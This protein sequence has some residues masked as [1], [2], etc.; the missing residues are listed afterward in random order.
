MTRGAAYDIADH[1]TYWVA[2]ISGLTHSGI[3]IVMSRPDRAPGL[4]L[5]RFLGQLRHHRR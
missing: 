1:E 3:I 4:V 5:L 2:P